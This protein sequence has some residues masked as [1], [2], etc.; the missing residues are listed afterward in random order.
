MKKGLLGL[1]LALLCSMSWAQLTPEKILACNKI[2]SESKR[3]ACFEQAAGVPSQAGGS[4]AAALPPGDLTLKGAIE[5][6][7]GLFDT[8]QSRRSEA[9][10]LKPEGDDSN[11]LVFWPTNGV[12]K[13]FTCAV[14]RT[15]KQMVYIDMA[16]MKVDAKQHA[17][18]AA[19]NAKAAEQL[20]K[21]NSGDTAG[22]V[23]EAKAE[24]SRTFKDPSSAQWRNLYMAKGGMTLLCG[25]VNAKNSYG[26]YT[27]FK[28]FYSN[29][30]STF[31]ALEG[32]LNVFDRMWPK[33]CGEK[34]VDVQ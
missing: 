2:K 30:E 23:A 4:G 22:F 34:G 29:G 19:Q 11:I 14:N 17:A 28:R 13:D 26:A 8:L 27:G 15:S 5:V 12:Q 7:V 3:L 33:M 24:V 1:G 6:C 18:F 9:Q 31:T 16:G 25:E 32:S 20:K 10:E 21:I